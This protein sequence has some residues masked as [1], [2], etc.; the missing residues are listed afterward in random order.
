[1]RGHE[2][3]L[4]GEKDPVTLSCRVDTDVV[5]GVGGVWGE[6]LDDERVERSRGLLDCLGLAGTSLNPSSSLFPFLV[7][8]KQAGF[9]SSLDQLI[10]LSDE[11]RVEDPFG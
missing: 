2:V 11:L 6:G 9:S 4:L 8:A 5:L 1:M 10:R 7:Q 3:H